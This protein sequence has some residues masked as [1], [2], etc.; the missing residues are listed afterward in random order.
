MTEKLNVFHIALLIYMIELDIT[1]FSLSRVVAENIGTNGWVGVILLSA[2]ALVNIWMYRAVYVVGKGRS[3][4]EIAETVVPRA[5][6]IPCYMALSLFWIAVG[7]LVGK[8]F[9]T[10]YQ[11]LSF[12]STSEIMIFL[13]YCVL[14][15][16][17]LVK[18]LYSIVKATTVFFLITFALNILAPY[19]SRDWS[20]TRFTTSFF[21][22]TEKGHSLAGWTEVF[23]VNIGYELCM[24]LFPYV[25]RKSKLFK[26]VVAGHLLNTSVQ[27]LVVFIAFGF[28]SFQQLQVMEYP[29]LNTLEY[30][31][32][33]FI[34]RI[35]NLIYCV[36][37]FPNLVSSVMFCYAALAT[38]RRVFPK[39]KPKL[40]ERGIA[41]VLFGAGCVSIALNPFGN[42]L[43]N[44]Y[45]L[46]TILAFLIPALLIP[47]AYRMRRKERSAGHEESGSG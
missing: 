11:M 5:L 18:D 4:H 6:L 13:F 16:C 8:N 25:D 21:Q 10:L 23:I 35:D 45:Y 33:P 24:F 7:A 43:N 44:A 12:R 22:G 36:F 38:M 20:L 29:V 2:A 42:L 39:A 27:L 41:V 31:E 47:A 15:Y 30:F 28:F 9:I 26:G 14:I 3:V 32:F 37:L 17:L 34:N 40:L 19:F 46:E 1:I